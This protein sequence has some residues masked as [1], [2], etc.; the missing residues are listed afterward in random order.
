VSVVHRQFVGPDLVVE[1]VFRY[2]P[3]R[4]FSADTEMKFTDPAPAK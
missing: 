1:N 4:L 3:F 2:S